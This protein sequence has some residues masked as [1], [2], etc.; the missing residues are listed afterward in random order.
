M[1]IKG[2]LKKGE[3]Y[4]SVTLM[5][6]AKKLNGLPGVID[7]AVVMGT[8]ENRAIL[9]ASGLLLD[10][11]RI[12][13]DSDLL[14]AVKAND[15]AAADNAI[16]GLAGALVSL[17]QRGD[18]ATGY[19]PRSVDAA[20]GLLPGA[21]LALVSVAGRFAF[22]VA[23]KALLRG[24]H[25]MLFSDNVPLEQE[26]A[27]KTYAAERNLLVMGPDCGTAIVNGAPLAFANAVRRGDIGV[28]A[29]AGTGMQEVTTLISNAGAGISQAIGTGGRDI[30]KEVGGLM[31]LQGIQMLDEDSATKVILLVSKPPHP[32][33]LERIGSQVKAV[34]KPVV[35][36]FLGADPNTISSYGMR[37]AAT[38]YE[39]ARLAVSLSRHGTGTA[40]A[41]SDTD[42]EIESIALAEKVKLVHGQRYIR[43]LF[44][45][46]T[47][48]YES[49]LLLKEL[50][51][52]VH[53]NAPTGSSKKLENSM[54]SAGHTVVDLG[55]DEFTVGRPHPMIDFSLRNKR[56]VQEAQ[57]P[58]TAVI[59]LDLVLG[60][61]SNPD[62][63]KEIV[64]AI[65]EAH[66]IAKESGRSLPVVASVTGT[67]A[68]P[69]DR[70]VVVAGL[71][72]AGVL[73]ACS[74]A[75]A[76]RLAGMI[77][78]GAGK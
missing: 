19:R 33:V 8:K 45:G 37:P 2:I 24:L 75:E 30:K 4:D 28:V 31:F 27:L 17:R 18:G 60:Y 66:G 25:V 7:S 38:L 23:M 54:L 69:Q 73:V 29:A 40:E 13:I 71:K 53:S 76:C 32:E 62:P 55:E 36:V 70:S 6:A 10:E 48:C 15:A 57:D 61:G 74:N 63:L 67:D 26:I 20:I 47:F 49:Q 42:K 52:E 58:A 77:V 44:S 3:Y 65:K 39:A 43:G 16:A 9:E 78:K 35:A 72:N 14:V 34:K 64:P 68:D 11:F 59:L 51:D 5:T 22:D 21:N 41:Q 12:S 56:I 46:G 50:V 1:I